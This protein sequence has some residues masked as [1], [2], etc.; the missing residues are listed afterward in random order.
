[1]LMKEQKEKEW[2]SMYRKPSAIRH[3]DLENNDVLG[4][5]ARMFAEAGGS[6]HEEVTKR[7]S[8]KVSWNPITEAKVEFIFKV[9]GSQGW[10]CF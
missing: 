9:M 1:M 7:Q 5:A 4:G 2:H 3:R 8:R 10:T 6:M